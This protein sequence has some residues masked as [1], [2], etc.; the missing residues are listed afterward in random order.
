MNINFRP[1]IILLPIA[2]IQSSFLLNVGEAQQVLRYA[3]RKS[4]SGYDP[5]TS[6]SPYSQRVSSLIF[7]S[8]YSIG[9]SLTP[10]PCL[11]NRII[12]RGRNNITIELK[13]NV[14]WH[15]LQ[16][17]SENEYLTAR[18]V[19]FTFK[20]LSN[21]STRIMKRGI[22]GQIRRIKSIDIENENTIRITF[23]QNVAV[24]E[25]NL[26]FPIFPEHIIGEAKLGNNM[27][28]ARHPVGTGLFQYNSFTVPDNLILRLNKNYSR[29]T[30][31]IERI[32]I[33]TIPDPA[34][35]YQQVLP[36]GFSLLDPNVP[37]EYLGFLE[38]TGSMRIIPLSALSIDFIAYN[39]Q[40]PYLDNA[41]IRKAFSLS[42]N[43][44]SILN[45]VFL[46][47]GS[48]ISGPYSN[49][50]PGYNPFVLSLPY[51][52]TSARILLGEA[53][54]QSM[55]REGYLLDSIKTKLTYRLIRETGAEIDAEKENKF[56]TIADEFKR[57]LRQLGI[58]IIIEPLPTDAFNRAIQ[59]RDYDMILDRVEY[60]IFSEMAERF[61]SKNAKPDGENITEYK[62]KEADQ[63]IDRIFAARTAAE[64]RQYRRDFHSFIANECPYTF[65]WSIK[66]NAAFHKSVK[67]VRVHPLDFFKYINEWIID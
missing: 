16:G 21:P 5:I 63:L 35:L 55:N 65:L 48:L 2:F 56:P 37:P 4:P 34:L 42:I 66:R 19:V 39:C 67:K 52:T 26:M 6:E 53:G 49:Y 13:K 36:S 45:A 17:N 32:D 43:R 51:D 18:D 3:E 12:E 10:E 40:R 38:N 15:T 23:N 47:Q 29:R 33:K 8:L 25:Y 28:F 64:E 22:A 24:P 60:D 20:L 30:S 54:L 7:E 46:E 11:A 59:S 50:D 27:Y 41:K 9:D 57:N 44:S 14:V 1:C 31:Q 62:S 61:H 58:E